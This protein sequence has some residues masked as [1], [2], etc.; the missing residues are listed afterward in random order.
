MQKSKN[1]V[2]LKK[3]QL[4]RRSIFLGG[5]SIALGGFLNAK[6]IPNARQKLSL[7]EKSRIESIQKND[8]YQREI[9]A[10]REN[11]RVR[12]ES[13]A[14]QNNE[15]ASSINSKLKTTSP[16][17]LLISEKS[18]LEV[19]EY[20][21]RNSQKLSQ[22]K[23]YLSAQERIHNR[24]ILEPIIRRVAKKHG[25]SGDLM[26]KLFQ[27]ESGWDPFI[28]GKNKDVGLGQLTPVIWDSKIISKY[29][30][31]PL[32]PIENIE[33]SIRYYS[34]LLK[35][36]GNDKLALT[37]YNSGET[38]VRNKLRAGMSIN[39]IV[40]ANKH[41]YANRVLEQKI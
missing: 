23:R 35:K 22:N 12:N 3:G 4:I 9:N 30:C 1:K 29:N 40:L 7:I 11:A 10:I 36:F 13:Y 32:N 34:D 18:H 16:E 39:E 6:I 38:F 20:L 8:A 28:I 5:L 27:N 26:I 21:I 14:R 41:V 19:K 25:V 24:E 37:A 31:N 33:V 2:A 17:L 15:K